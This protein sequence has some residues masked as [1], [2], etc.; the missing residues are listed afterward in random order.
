MTWESFSIAGEF[1]FLGIEAT[2]QNG[3]QMRPEHLVFGGEDGSRTR[4]DGFAGRF[5]PYESMS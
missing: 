3:P 1:N 5:G 2:K 4:L